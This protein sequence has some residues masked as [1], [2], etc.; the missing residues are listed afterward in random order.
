MV[1]LSDVM[2]GFF[3][4]MFTFLRN[5]EMSQLINIQSALT[6]EQKNNLLLLRDLVNRSD[7][8]SNGFFNM[9]ASEDEFYKRNLFIHGN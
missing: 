9:V 2:A 7:S 1:Q 5:T 3:A 4:K 6:T 8:I